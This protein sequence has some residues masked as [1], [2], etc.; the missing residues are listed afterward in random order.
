MKTEREQLEQNTKIAYAQQRA[1]ELGNTVT[2]LQEERWEA[3]RWEFRTS[4]L[5]LLN[6]LSYWIMVTY[7]AFTDTAPEIVD[8]ATD[9]WLLLFFFLIL[10]E[11]HYNKRFQYL[12]GKIDGILV[13]L[14]TLF[15]DS[16]RDDEGNA[17]RKVKRRSMFKRFKE[18]IER[19]GQSQ[20]KEVPA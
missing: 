13:A 5:N 18:F 17:P 20:T 9:F 19:I 14:E 7:A 6:I 12:D 16:N 11:H 10:R 3:K 2:R 8:T 15:P 1:E 4:S